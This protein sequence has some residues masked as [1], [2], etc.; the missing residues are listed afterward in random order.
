NDDQSLQ[1]LVEVADLVDA[2]LVGVIVVGILLKVVRTF[3]CQFPA[4]IALLLVV[5]PADQAGKDA[6]VVL[7]LLGEGQASL[8]GLLRALLE[9]SRPGDLALTP[10][11]AGALR[12]R[13]ARHL[14]DV[15]LEAIDGSNL[16]GKLLDGLAPLR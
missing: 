5:L 2:R 8:K 14:N 13:R 11:I 15:A 9:E 6:S 7:D 16:V 1:P 3:L 10:P 12:R 4:A